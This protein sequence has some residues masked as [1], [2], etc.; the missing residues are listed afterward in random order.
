LVVTGRHGV[1]AQ[2][3]H[4]GDQSDAAIEIQTCASANVPSDLSILLRA[5]PLW[6]PPPTAR[7][8]SH[9]QGA[10]GRS[11]GPRSRPPT[12][13]RPLTLPAVDASGATLKGSQLPESRRQRFG[14]PRPRKHW[15]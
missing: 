14:A 8:S 2:D 12:A 6:I 15:E 5:V 4:E 13:K 7:R 3:D 11:S 9:G 10:V 1:R